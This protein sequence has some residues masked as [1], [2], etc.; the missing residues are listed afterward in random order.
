MNILITGGAGFIGSHIVEYHLSQKD[1]VYVIDNLITGSI[2]NL[3]HLKTDASLHIITEDLCTY[4]FTDIPKIDLI[5]HMASPASP[6]QYKKHPIETMMVNA[7][8]TRNLLEFMRTSKSTSLVIAS[9]SEVYGDPEVHPQTEEYWGNVNSV[10]VRSCYDE[11]KRYAE[12]LCMSYIRQYNLDIRIARIFNTYGPHMEREDGRI[13]SN[14]VVQA[15]SNQPITI[16][17]D[18]TQTRSFC[19]VSD[20]VRGLNA[21]V[22][23][24]NLRGQVI[25]LGNPDERSVK[26]MAELIQSLTQSESKIIYTE[27]GSDDP[28]KRKPE[29]SKARKMLFWEP[30]VPLETGLLKTIDYFKDIIA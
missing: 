13:I 22:R 8:G 27:I 19:Y 12:A 4:R 30:S 15:L 14:F 11:A 18:G 25:N 28:K 21:L 2:R 7:E 3:E 5:Y 1:T 23:L 24:P 17:G 16:Y 6:I 20:L 29:I 9:T 10:G 26:E